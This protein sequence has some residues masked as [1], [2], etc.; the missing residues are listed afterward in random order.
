MAKENPLQLSQQALTTFNANVNKLMK[1]GEK[2]GSPA[3]NKKVRATMYAQLPIFLA[4]AS[5]RKRGR[6]SSNS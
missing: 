1:E 3:D 4:L 2:I 6:T 5:T